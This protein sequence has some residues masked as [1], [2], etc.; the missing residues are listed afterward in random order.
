MVTEHALMQ[1]REL[2][3]SAKD[4]VERIRE[5]LGRNPLDNGNNP[6]LQRKA[7]AIGAGGLGAG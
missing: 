2:E 4:L 7:A 6:A 5:E 1:E 3:K